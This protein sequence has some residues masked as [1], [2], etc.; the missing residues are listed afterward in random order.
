ME[1]IGTALS[2]R[3]RTKYFGNV[4]LRNVLK[5]D[6]FMLGGGFS[7]VLCPLPLH[8]VHFGTAETK[9]VGGLPCPASA[10]QMG[11]AGKESR[12]AGGG[13]ASAWS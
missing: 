9:F 5:E 4:I 7:R 11:L 3:H 6:M 8:S 2:C 12:L 1:E 13:W 10:G